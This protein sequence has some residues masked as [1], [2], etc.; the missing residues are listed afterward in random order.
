MK[1]PISSFLLMLALLLPAGCSNVLDEYEDYPTVDWYPV[2]LI[3]TVQDKDGKDL[4]DPAVKGNY[5][6][7]SSLTFQGKTYEALELGRNESWQQTPT[8]MYLA[9][10]KGFRLAYDT[11]YINE[12]ETRECYFLVFGQIDGARDMDEDLILTWPD[13]SEET[14]HYHCSK[15]KVEKNRKSGD[16]NVSCERSWTLNG[17][18]AGNPFLFVK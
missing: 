13:G 2:N 5:F 6:N 9:R 7:G 18:E 1:Y 16:W 10:I 12:T 4:L 17:E 11:I 3:V 15:H 14:I 8:K